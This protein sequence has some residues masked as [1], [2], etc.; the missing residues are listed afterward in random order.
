MGRRSETVE[1]A[2]AS[3]STPVYLLYGDDFRVKQAARKLVD[4]LCSP[5]EQVFGLEEIESSF[6]TVDQAVDTLRKLLL[7]VDTAGFL[8]GRKV[9]WFRADG[10]F[11]ESRLL[12]KPAVAQWTDQLVERIRSGLPEGRQLVVTAEGID[13][14]SA[15]YKAF[16]DAG[17]A[18]GYTLP[19]KS[20]EVVKYA[21]ERAGAA[22]REAGL[23]ADRRAVD[24]FVDMIG[25]DARTIQSEVDKLALFT[26]GREA[27]TVDDVRAVTSPAREIEAW[28][29]ADRI[30]E[31]DATGALQTLRLLLRQKVEPIFLVGGLESR[32]RDLSIYRDG[33]DR[34]WLSVD[35]RGAEWSGD[36]ECSVALAG[37][38]PWNPAGTHPYRAGLLA[39]QARKYSAIELARAA[40]AITRAREQMVGGFSAADLLLEFLVLRI[41]RKPKP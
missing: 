17:E 25:P 8:G 32:I 11:G 6:D 1:E 21:E 15:L 9:V 23:R 33:L 22:F 10:L 39:R 30:G 4:A 20:W 36:P 3:T 16:N 13:R 28:D 7:A 26:A 31:R 40:A 37:L 5:D 38:G 41:T 18:V 35:D 29:L 19:Q 27:V 34:G 14:R 24:V 2:K 12:K